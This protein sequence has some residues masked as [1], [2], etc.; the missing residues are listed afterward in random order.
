MKKHSFKD[1]KR[2]K[3][4]KDARKSAHSVVADF[5]REISKEVK[6]LQP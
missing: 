5:K 1:Y 4:L 3:I 6:S 2:E